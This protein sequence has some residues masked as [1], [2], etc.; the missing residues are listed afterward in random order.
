[1]KKILAAARVK[2]FSSPAFQETREFFLALLM[3]GKPD[4]HH[5]IK[6]ALFYFSWVSL[7]TQ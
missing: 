4:L 6:I 3:N 7:V 2:I 1:M 5:S